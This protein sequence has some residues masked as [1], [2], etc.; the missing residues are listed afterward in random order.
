M[1][2]EFYW[3]DGLIRFL[4]WGVVADLPGASDEVLDKMTDVLNKHM[5][6]WYARYLRAQS[7]AWGYEG[8]ATIGELAAEYG[9]HVTTVYLAL[10]RFGV[11]LRHDGR[12]E[13]DAENAEDAD[14]LAKY[15]EL[16]NYAAV[17][18]HFGVSR[19]RAHQRIKRARAARAGGEE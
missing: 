1:S 12:G 10:R 14:F 16:R 8:G 18:R 3:K 11:E 19:Q 9:V 6:T 13:H 4:G 15:N 5:A 2:G 7:I 17:G